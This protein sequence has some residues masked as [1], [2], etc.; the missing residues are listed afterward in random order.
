MQVSSDVHLR[1]MVLLG[2]SDWCKTT[3]TSV[4]KA[5][6]ISRWAQEVLSVVL[7]PLLGDSHKTN[8]LAGNADRG[9]VQESSL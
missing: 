8:V 9:L 2:S 4:I 6:S 3:V 5:L 1:Q 7:Q